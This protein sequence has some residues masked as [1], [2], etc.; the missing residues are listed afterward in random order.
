MRVKSAGAAGTKKRTKLRGSWLRK[1]SRELARRYPINWEESLQILSF[2]RKTQPDPAMDWSREL[3]ITN[4]Y[5][6]I[7]A[8]LGESL[9]RGSELGPHGPTSVRRPVQYSASAVAFLLSALESAEGEHLDDTEQAGRMH[10]LSLV[11]R[12]IETGEGETVPESPGVP[13]LVSA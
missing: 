2:L 5:P 11:A 3:R 1:A 10:L 12:V 7:H 8:W 13:S 4:A 6:I 9:V